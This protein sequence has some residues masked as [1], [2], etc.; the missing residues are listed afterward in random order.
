MKWK[1]YQASVKA[2][3][4][5][6]MFEGYA[7]VF[8]NIDSYGDVVEKGAFADTLTEWDASGKTLPVLFGHDFSDPFSNIGGVVSA[9]ED[10]HGLKV[11][12][13]LDL[14]NP[15]AAQVYRLL[16][17]GRISDM[18]FA[19]DVTDSGRGQVDGQD[20]NLLK[21]LKLYEV[22]IV[23]V[24]ANA[25]AGVTDVKA[26]AREL[27]SKAGRVISAKN[28]D[29]LRGALD[30]LKSGVEHIE[31]VLSCIGEDESQKAAT[32]ADEAKTEEPVGAKAEEPYPSGLAIAALAE[33][34]IT[35][36]SV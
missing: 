32:P 1:S 29:E 2:A 14:D 10:D 3:G 20:V 15:K 27:A 36:P 30:S 11:T 13:R 35:S 7:S 25:E 28:E 16:K 8:G 21:A 9:V 19:F 12:G 5:D 24:G 17:G 23:P 6:G 4:D 26:A 34:A 31:S 22:S 33:F 18:S